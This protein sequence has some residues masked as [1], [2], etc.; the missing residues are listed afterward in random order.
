[1]VNGLLTT[2]QR[3]R[4]ATDA[5][6]GIGAEEVVLYCCATDPDQVDRLTDAL[7]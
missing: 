7:F 3:I 4:E 6:F 5:L 1:M 2:P